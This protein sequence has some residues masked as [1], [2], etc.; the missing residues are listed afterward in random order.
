MVK[1]GL[2]SFGVSTSGQQKF[3]PPPYE[4]LNTPL[5]HAYIARLL[6]DFFSIFSE[7]HLVIVQRL[8]CLYKISTN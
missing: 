4:F 8:C 1:L 6:N 3:A 5:G 2:A 7:D